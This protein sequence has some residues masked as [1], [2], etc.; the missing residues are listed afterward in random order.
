MTRKQRTAVQNG[1]PVAVCFTRHDLIIVRLRRVNRWR[2][3]ARTGGRFAVYSAFAK[4][5][6]LNS[7]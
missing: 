1:R 3:A 6:Q 2:L 4:T 5:E 7:V